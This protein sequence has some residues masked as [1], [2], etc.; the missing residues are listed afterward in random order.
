MKL[1]SNGL[2]TFLLEDTKGAIKCRNSKKDRQWSGQRKKDRQYSGQRKK[3]NRHQT[4]NDLQ[5]HN[6]ENYE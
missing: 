6:T 5:I 3:D 4:N 2:R 1:L